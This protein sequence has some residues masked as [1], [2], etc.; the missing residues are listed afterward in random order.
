[1]K[2]APGIT[3][4]QGSKFNDKL[5]GSNI[6][7]IARG[8]K[9]NDALTGNA[10]NDLLLGDAG[11]DK[12]TGG[13]G[14]DALKGGAGN[15]R[16][17]G[18]DGKGKLAGQNGNDVLIGGKGRDVLVG[19][20]GRDTFVYET[21]KDSGDRIRAF[22][23]TDDLIDLRKIFKQPRFAGDNRFARYDQYIDLVQVGANTEVQIDIDGNGSSVAMTTLASLQGIQASTV[24]SQNFVIG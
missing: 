2:A 7:D 3:K 13:K 15:D 5:I 4:L 21:L 24:S 16:L 23:V 8:G 18:G 6:K 9:G 19:N 1:L 12:I 11:N 10:G 20:K 14:N 17:V 22:N